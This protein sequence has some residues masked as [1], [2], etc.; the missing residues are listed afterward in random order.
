MLASTTQ[1][2][3]PAPS[4][5]STHAF[6]KKLPHQPA[7]RRSQTR[8]APQIRDRATPISRAPDSPHSRTRSAAQIPPRPKASAMVFA[9][10]PQNILCAADQQCRDPYCLQDFRAATRGDACGFRLRLFERNSGPQPR[11]HSQPAISASKY[12]VE[13]RGLGNTTSCIMT[14][15]QISA[16]SLNP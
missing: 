15:I 8:R 9:L 6:C 10:R 12:N 13:L 5:A 2:A 11:H 1:I 3:A 16:L 4:D 7:A 14:G